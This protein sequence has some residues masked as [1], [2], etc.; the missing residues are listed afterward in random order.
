MSRL[1]EYYRSEVVPKLMK[2]MGY[3]NVYEVPRIIKIVIN[4][5]LGEAISDP[6]IIDVASSDLSLITGQKPLVIK[7]KRN[8][9]SFKLRKGIPIALKVTLRKSRAYDFLDRLINFAL[10]RVKDFRG[11]PKDGFDGHGNYNFGINEHTIFPEIDID[12]VQK[13]FGMDITIVT[14]AKDDKSAY[15]LLKSLNFP[16]ERG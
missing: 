1:L 12:K 9:A 11:L 3:K 6:K 16:F 13:V 2:E 8:I 14:S 5:A 15:E 7:A 4:S 10:P